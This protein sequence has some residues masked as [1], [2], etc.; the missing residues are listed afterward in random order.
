MQS[1]LSVILVFLAIGIGAQEQVNFDE[2]FLDN[3]MRIDYCHMGDASAEWIAIDRIYRQGIWAGSRKNLID[4]LNNGSYCVK[5][6]DS[7]SSRL[8]FSKGFDCF[9][10]EYQTTDPAI[11]GI[12]R[13]YYESAL[14]PYPRKKIRFTVEKRDKTKKFQMVFSQEIDP[15]SIFVNREALIEGVKV[16]KVLQNGYP[17]DKVDLVFIGVGY[18]AADEEKFQRDLLRSCLIFL[19]HEPYRTYQSRFN[20]CGVFKASEERGCD[21]PSYGV[22]K[23]TNIDLTFDSLGSERYLMTEDNKNLRDIAAHV[24]YDAVYLIVN[25]SR[26]GGGGIYNLY[27]TFPADNEW[28]SYLL[29]HEFGH[30]FA[31][32]ADEYYSSSTAYVDFFPQGVEPVEP[33]IT[34]L[35][36]AG[37]VKWKQFLSPG[38]GVP[39][40]WGKAVYDGMSD[41]YQ[42]QRGIFNEKIAGMMRAGA[43]QD[44]IEKMKKEAMS[45]SFLHQEEEDRFLSDSGLM[46]KVGV[47]EGAGYVSKG[48]YRPMID[49]IMFSKGAKPYCKVCEAAVI[50]VIR[51]YS[52]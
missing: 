39:T 42:K 16:V 48:L 34:A 14:I 52:D 18:T 8:I 50:R 7:E 23:N 36:D 46:D 44:E 32:L 28:T 21:E 27:A 38:I 15:Q 1:Y 2:Y 33:N 51:H 6:Y 30:S 35:L 47:F 43:P 13:T 41:A 19:T 3:T 40:D 5:I 17:Q 49:C 26:Y 9:F 24:P 4:E 10:G 12:K 45:L 25:H 22:Y 11:N 37:D 29:L 20:I 31:G